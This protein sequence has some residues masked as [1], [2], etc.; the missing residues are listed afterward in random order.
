MPYIYIGEH[1][2]LIEGVKSIRKW[3]SGTI[4]VVSP[5]G[6]IRIT[7]KG[8]EINQRTPDHILIQGKTLSIEFEEKRK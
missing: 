8:L 7:G 4:V 3:E 2:I 6:S 1:G 5:L